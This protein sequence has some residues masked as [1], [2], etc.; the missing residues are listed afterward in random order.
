MHRSVIFMKYEISEDDRRKAK[1]PHEIFLINLIG[2]HILWFIASLGLAGQYWQP[3]ALVPVVS[4]VILSY[5]L[6]RAKRAQDS[7][8]WFVACHWQMTA[9]R[10]KVFLCVLG[11]LLTAALLGWVGYTYFGMM[12]IAVKALVGG[13]GVLPV[14][15]VTLV[16]IVMESDA[17]HQSS[18]GIVPDGVAKLIPK[19]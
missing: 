12:D 9:K 7:A 10:S 3:L 1:V 2:N 4:I 6:W 17:L 5:I 8:P 16:L 18:Q 13:I 19:S 11:V 14:V 15:V